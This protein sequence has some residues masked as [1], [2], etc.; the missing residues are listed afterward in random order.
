[1]G[2][3]AAALALTVF[4]GLAAQEAKKSFEVVRV[5]RCDAGQT[6]RFDPDR[7]E[8]NYRTV[9]ANLEQ[10]LARFEE[11]ALARME[12]GYDAGLPDPV[13]T[14]R[15]TWRPP[16]PLP[17]S[18]RGAAIHVVTVDGDGKIH[19][20]PEGGRRRNDIVLI[21]RAARLKDCARLGPVTFMTRDLAARLGLRSS[22]GRC[23]VSADGTEVEITEGEAP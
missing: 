10:A 20:L 8:R 5:S 19:G 12:D 1:M 9:A 13:R 3:R 14:V 22:R 4:A 6:I 17:E 11:K 21:S 18:I 2:G 7:V 15:R 16:M 23:V